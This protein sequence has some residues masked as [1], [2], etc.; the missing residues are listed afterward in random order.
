[1]VLL[2]KVVIENEVGKLRGNRGGENVYY[3][4]DLFTEKALDFIQKNR[5]NPFFLYLSY[6][7]P[8]FSDYDKDTPEHYIVPSDE[9]Y[10]TDL[11]P[12]SLRTTP[13]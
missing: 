10:L 13:P 2:Q 3:T 8:H 7:I 12:R 9:P 11:G 1:M 5:E 6:T 4:H